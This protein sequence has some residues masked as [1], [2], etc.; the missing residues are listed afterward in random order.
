MLHIAGVSFHSLFPFKVV[1]I[2]LRFSFANAG[3][4]CALPSQMQGPL[5][6]LAPHIHDLSF[7]TRIKSAGVFPVTKK[8]GGMLHHRGKQT[9]RL[10]AGRLYVSLTG[11]CTANHNLPSACLGAF[12]HPPSIHVRTLK[13][14]SSNLKLLLFLDEPVLKL[15]KA[16]CADGYGR[17]GILRHHGCDAGLF[18]DQKIQTL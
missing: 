14:T 4:A 17:H 15:Q 8:A 12:R 3:P 11:S 7:Y 16:S 13:D 5:A 6:R 1:R 9:R 10:T 2:C 18:L